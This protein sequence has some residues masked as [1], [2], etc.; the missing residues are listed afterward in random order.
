MKREDP[1]IMCLQ[2][3]FDAPITQPSQFQSVRKLK[4]L[5]PLH[6]HAYAPEL[7]EVRTDGEGDTGNLIISRFPIS[8][9][10]T[11]F[12]LGEYKKITRPEK[13]EF[14]NYP[15][16]MQCA[17]IELEGKKQLHVHNLHGIWGLDGADTPER[18]RMSHIITSHLQSNPHTLLM[19][20]FNLKPE[21]QTI[22]NIEKQMVS[23]F[24][25][26]MTTS[27]NMQHK[28]NPGYA[29]AV[30]D[31]VFASPDVRVV[32]KKVLEDDVS[33]HKPLLFEIAY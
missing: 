23:V 13:I 21:N 5:F 31:M 27:F 30:V 28:T 26:D 12:L 18:L 8:Q 9:S 25:N 22:Y 29:T 24:K 14:S 4:E 33:D 17:H 19:G 10:E 32:S 11:I 6:Y 3:A 15:K 16:N 20:D 1:D 2:E 7:Y